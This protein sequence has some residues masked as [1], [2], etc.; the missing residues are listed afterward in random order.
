MATVSKSFT[1]TGVSNT[2]SVDDS[3]ETIAFNMSGTYVGT[4]TVEKA[5]TADQA[6]WQ[7]VLGPFVGNNTTFAANYVTTRRNTRFRLRCTAF[8]SG[9]IVTSIADGDKTLKNYT[10][11][12]GNIVE[13]ITQSAR[14][15]FSYMSN[16]ISGLALAMGGRQSVITGASADVTNTITET[17]FSN[18]TVT[19][20]ANSLRAGSTVRIKLQGIAPSTNATDTLRIKL[21]VNG[22][23]GTNLFTMGPTDVAN[24]DIFH[25]EYTLIFRAVGASGSMVGYG[26]GKNV[27]AAEGTIAVRDDILAAT[28]IDTTAAITIDVTATWSVANAGNIARL[29]VYDVRIEP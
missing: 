28:T 12:I 29:D 1:A 21:N 11:P 6:A 7:T 25:C 23:G 4:V 14:S 8:T 2:L 26:W 24:N 18:G 3:G 20:P 9:T 13:T 16:T 22:T 27:P 19:I 17:I 10:D 5:T 15:F